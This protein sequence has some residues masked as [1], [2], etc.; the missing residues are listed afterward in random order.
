MAEYA[1]TQGIEHKPVFNWWVPQVLRL[2]KCIISLVKK[3][4]MSYLKKN[5][6]FGIEVPTSVNHDLEIDKRNGNTLWADLIA[7]EMKDV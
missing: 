3:R 7:K 4:K 1:I 5:M 2:R 6:K